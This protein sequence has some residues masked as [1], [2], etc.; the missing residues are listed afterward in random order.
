MQATTVLCTGSQNIEGGKEKTLRPAPGRLNVSLPPEMRQPINGE[1]QVPCAVEVKKVTGVP[2]PP[3]HTV[4]SPRKRYD[5]IRHK[6]RVAVPMW[7]SKS[8][9]ISAGAVM[10]KGWHPLQRVQETHLDT[11]KG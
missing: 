2:R 7:G 6:K 3:S 5:R 4:Y 10:H 1:P 8:P 11:V 9:A